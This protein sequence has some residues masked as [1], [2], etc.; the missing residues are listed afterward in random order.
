MTSA[1]APQAAS[2]LAQ[3]RYAPQT[4]EPDRPVDESLGRLDEEK[5]APHAWADLQLDAG[6]EEPA[7]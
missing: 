5:P 4:R 7:S 3:C 2:V 1:N 6:A